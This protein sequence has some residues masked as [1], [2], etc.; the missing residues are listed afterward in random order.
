M[1][2]DN[3]IF[4]D[5]TFQNGNRMKWNTQN[6]KPLHPQ[7]IKGT[8]YS[9]YDELRQKCNPNN[10]M[11]PYDF[12]LVK[13]SNAIYSQ[14]ETEKDNEKALRKIRRRAVEELGIIVSTEQLYNRLKHNLDPSKYVGHREWVDIAND[15]YNQVLCNADN[16]EE[17]ERIE[18]CNQYK[19]LIEEYR[20]YLKEKHKVSDQEAWSILWKT[21]A[22]IAIPALLILIVY[23]INGIFH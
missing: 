4:E 21:S 15:L 1:E 22:I 5:M 17:L 2:E 20:K 9:L 14:I 3:I 13:L 18:S 16:I 7:P 8:Y 6:A 19:K 11:H 10:F 23:I 12:E